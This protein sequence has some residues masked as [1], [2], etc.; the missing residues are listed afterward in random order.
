MTTHVIN[1]EKIHVKHDYD[2][3]FWGGYKFYAITDGYDPTPVYSDE[4]WGDTT[5]Y[6][7]TEQEAI[8]DLLY[9]LEEL[10]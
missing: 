1:G 5:G 10:K 3:E 7:D 8:D 9:Q 2:S 6:G 4:S